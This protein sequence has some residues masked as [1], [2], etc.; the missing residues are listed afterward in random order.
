MSQDKPALYFISVKRIL[1]A[2]NFYFPPFIH[3]SNRKSKAQA[4][5]LSIFEAGTYKKAVSVSFLNGESQIYFD[6]I[7]INNKAHR[8]QDNL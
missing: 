6:A 3:T 8:K 7:L 1:I 2:L 5:V 4:S